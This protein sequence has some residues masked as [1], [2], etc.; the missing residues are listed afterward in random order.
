MNYGYLKLEIYTTGCKLMK[1]LKQALP[2]STGR[3]MCTMGVTVDPSTGLETTLQ[4]KI[5][6]S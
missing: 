6:N 3:W 4:S 5:V 1:P 2:Q